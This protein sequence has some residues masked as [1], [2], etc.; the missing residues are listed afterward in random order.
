M[1]VSP[2]TINRTRNYSDKICSGNQNTHFVP[3]NCFFFINRA[4]YEIM[5][6]NTVRATDDKNAHALRM[7]D[8]YGYKH[9]LRISNTYCFSIVSMKLFS[10]LRYMH[11]AGLVAM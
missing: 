8:N 7:L 1:I 6:K 9:T 11:I 2:E 3:N 5:R 4:V 10:M